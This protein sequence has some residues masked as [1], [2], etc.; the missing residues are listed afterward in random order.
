MV[1][2]ALALAL[3]MAASGPKV[4]P[5][6]IDLDPA[7]V[8]PPPPRADGVQAKA[9]LAELHAAEAARS[10]ADEAVARRDGDTK[11]ASI[12]A[13]VLGPR[14]DLDRLPETGLLMAMTRATEKATIDRGK[15][16]FHRLRPYAVDPT[17][18]SCKRNEDLYSSYPSGHTAMAYAMGEVLARLVPTRAA[19][20]LDRA[21]G[22]AQTRIVCGQH[23]RSDVSAGA[24]LGA[25]VA[26]RLMALP[27]F[28]RQ[29]SKA[30]TELAAAGIR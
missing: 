8:L 15:S 25:L 29:F 5:L 9:E 11:N 22:Y 2:L 13:G 12:F 21:A 1:F 30:R 14:F 10:P 20:I 28:A 17:L 23:W 26:E 3:A 6:P 24:V 19:A 27:A 16:A 4:A 7:R 18:H